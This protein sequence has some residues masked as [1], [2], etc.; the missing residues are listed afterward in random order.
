MLPSAIASYTFHG[1]DVISTGDIFS[2]VT[3]PVIDRKHGGT[4]WENP[5]RGQGPIMDFDDRYG[6][7]QFLLD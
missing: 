5:G 7:P 3:Y 6:A 4:F 1:S 2:T